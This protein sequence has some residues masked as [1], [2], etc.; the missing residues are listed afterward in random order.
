M[1]NLL[2][3]C[4]A[5][6]LFA[7]SNQEHVEERHVIIDSLSKHFEGDAL[8]DAVMKNE[9]F[10][11]DEVNYSKGLEDLIKITDETK[12]LEYG[13]KLRMSLAL[14]LADI[15][16]KRAIELLKQAKELVRDLEKKKLYGFAMQNIGMTY[17]EKLHDYENTLL[18]IDSAIVYWQSIN[19]VRA[20]ANLLKYKGL[21]QGKL[22]AFEEAKKTVREGIRLCHLNDFRAIEA[23]SYFDLANVFNDEGIA[24][25][26]IF[27]ANKALDFW[28]GQDM[29]DLYRINGLN[30]FLLKVY[31][32][33]NMEDKIGPQFLMCENSIEEKNTH[34]MI[35]NDFYKVAIEYKKSLKDGS[36]VV[37][38][39]K[40][41]AYASYLKEKGIQS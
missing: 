13:G 3:I 9:I 18:Y 32:K 19:D 33:Y 23:V 17:E 35:V 7:C 30:V 4:S 31:Q 25:S 15:D 12:N 40:L 29:K 39:E 38:E 2:I 24:D 10:R 41:K 37:Y 20:E 11:N 14:A 5:L 28:Y 36:H 8:V 6:F 21:I 34:F 16:P 1:R 27:F 22:G 26:S